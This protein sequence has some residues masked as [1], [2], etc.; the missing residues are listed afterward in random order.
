VARAPSPRTRHEPWIRHHGSDVA[1]D[2]R[3]Q[4]LHHLPAG[5]PSTQSGASEARSSSIGAHH[6]A[7]CEATR[8]RHESAGR[9]TAAGGPARSDVL[10]LE[11]AE[12][13]GDAVDRAALAD[14][15]STTPGSEPGR[16]RAPSLPFHRS[17]AAPRPVRRPPGS[18]RGPTSIMPPPHRP[19]RPRRTRHFAAASGI[20]ISAEHRSAA[21]KAWR[22]D[23]VLSRGSHTTST[24]RSS[25]AG[26]AGPPLP[27]RQN[28]SGSASARTGRGRGR[29]RSPRAWT[30]GSS[31][32]ETAAS[33]SR[34]LQRLTREVHH[35]PTGLEP[36]A[37]L[38]PPTESARSPDSP[39]RPCL[40]HSRVQSAASGLKSSRRAAQPLVRVTPPAGGDACARRARRTTSATTAASFRDSVHTKLRA[41]D[42]SS[43]TA[44]V[45]D[46]LER[47]PAPPEAEPLGGEIEVARAESVAESARRLGA[48]GHRRRAASPTEDRRSVQLPPRLPA[49]R[50]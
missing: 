26:S 10:V 31:E 30:N 14:R 19:A 42:A 15:P 28:A 35:L 12:S 37:R 43:E 27:D 3:Q 20:E 23:A 49:V 39:S 46:R 47:R 33:R 44:R 34:I 48:P 6:L 9:L 40:R 5:T 18:A 1:F 8:R 50:Q 45:R 29:H 4:R 13:G 32:T 36:R 21:R 22:Y 41:S 25:A 24:P 11:L 17:A 38:P 16:S 2:H 7:G